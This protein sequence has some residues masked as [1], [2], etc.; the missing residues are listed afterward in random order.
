MMIC[1]PS[2]SGVSG[3]FMGTLSTRG[4]D[5]CGCTINFGTFFFHTTGSSVL[6]AFGD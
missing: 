3:Q 2:P 4:G 5:G 1:Y 6:I